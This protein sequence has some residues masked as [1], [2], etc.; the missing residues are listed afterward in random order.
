MIYVIKGES[1]LFLD[2]VGDFEEWVGDA[3]QFRTP[4]A[5]DIMLE[6]QRERYKQGL[7]F[8]LTPEIREFREKHLKALLSSRVTPLR[9]VEPDGGP[10][11]GPL[12]PHCHKHDCD[13]LVEYF[14]TQQA[15]SADCT[16]AA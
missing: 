10:P 4:V 9:F 6:G 15:T 12:C 2:R 5:A 11:T 13:W 3:H 16:G 7:E 8:A 1:G 14:N